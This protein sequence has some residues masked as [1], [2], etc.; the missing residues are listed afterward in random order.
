MTTIFYDGLT[1]IYTT[2]EPP[3]L[4]TLLS[5]YFHYQSLNPSNHCC[6]LSA[7]DFEVDPRKIRYFVLADEAPPLAPVTSDRPSTP[8][9]TSTQNTFISA[10]EI[11]IVSLSS[12][13]TDSQPQLEPQTSSSDPLTTT[14]ATPAPRTTR[15]RRRRS[16]F[17]SPIVSAG[18]THIRAEAET[19]LV[20]N[21]LERGSGPPSPKRQR[22]AG[23]NMRRESEKS[24]STS[25][26][27]RYHG[28]GSLHSQK[29]SES[30]NGH[31][32]TNGSESSHMNGSS[33]LNR[34]AVSPKFHGHSRE[35]VTRLLIQAL[36]DLGYRDSASHLVRESGHELESPSVAAFRQSILNGEW[37]EAEALLF[38]TGYR[39]EGGVSISNGHSSQH[40]GLPLAESA[41]KNSLR[42]LLRKQKY[43]ELL[44]ERDHGRA[45]MVLRQ[46]L[47]PLDQDVVQLHGL[48]G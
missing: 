25:N 43:L 39:D 22:L 19:G 13:A 4:R 32:H 10:P 30:S 42:F 15:R 45:L 11:P 5:I 46:E 18:G 41:D 9:P 40:Q 21:P 12:A 36:G 28:N 6:Y 38:G 44:E 3:L 34:S 16:S 37:A 23:N 24:S 17:D 2:A 48:S 8:T 20:Q 47:T 1:S 35:E 29:G 14:L 7:V 31:A 27:T 26:G 33:P